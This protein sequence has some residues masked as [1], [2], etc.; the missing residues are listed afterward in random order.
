MQQRFGTVPVLHVAG[1][2][3]DREQHADGVGQQVA[4]AADDLLAGIITPRLE[5]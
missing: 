1:V 4:L 3:E 2:D 5:R